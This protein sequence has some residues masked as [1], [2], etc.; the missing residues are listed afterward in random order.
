[1]LRVE[2]GERSYP[3]WIGSGLLADADLLS[4]HLGRGAVA[5][6]SSTAVSALYLPRLR[7]ALGDR[8][9]AVEILPDGEQ[10]KTL[11]TVSRIYD[12]LAGA[13]LGRD[14]T[15]I[16][17]GGG[18]V[19]DMTGFAAATWQRGID[20]VQVPT[21][22]LAQVDSSVGGKTG[23]NHARGKNLIGAF[24]QPRCVLADIDTLATLPERELAAGFAEVLKYGLIGD[25]AF[26]DWMRLQ[27]VAL[28]A[29]EPHALGEAVRRSCAAKAQ[30]VA[31]DEREAEGGRRALLNF[32][33]TFGHALETLGGYGRLL[34]GEAV[35]IGMAMAAQM[36]CRMG[37][38]SAAEVADVR[39]V[40]RA[41][42]LPVDPP[43]GIDPAE[44][45]DAMHGDKKTAAGRLRLVLLRR[46]G[47]AVLCADFPAAEL[48]A[49]LADA[50]AGRA[51]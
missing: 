36:S 23:V 11:Q 33:H 21:T 43:P 12:V 22:L 48:R 1:M 19:G 37:W 15:L 26:F 17:L 2:L 51:A 13:R 50:C 16:A 41:L 6:V 45:L 46:P 18:V 34:H 38:I 30:V 28:R 8:L 29:R 42:G 25:T 49:V 10:H 7:S 44:F 24:H 39:A 47:D 20:F 3:I 40:L 32:G 9:A 4:R 14:G 27:A 31:G 5:V 35:A